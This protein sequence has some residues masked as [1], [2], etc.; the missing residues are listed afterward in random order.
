MN[1]PLV[2]FSKYL[3]CIIIFFVL[4]TC[5]T[6]FNVTCTSSGRRCR[7]R[8]NFITKNVRNPYF[9]K[10]T[11]VI[12]PRNK[13]KLC[14]I[15]DIKNVAFVRNCQSYKINLLYSFA[16]RKKT[17]QKLSGDLVR[18]LRIIKQR[19]MEKSKRVFTF[20]CL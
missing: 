18:Y 3:N 19:L 5:A 6:L 11:I 15:F 4:I 12:C 20:E 1:K 10:I 8:T 14:N 2:S 17:V 9:I 13:K 16:F 7:W